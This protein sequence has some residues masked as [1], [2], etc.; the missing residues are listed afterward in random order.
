L[1]KVLKGMNK[2]NTYSIAI[3]AYGRPNELMELFDS[4]YQMDKQP[5]EIIICEDFSKDRKK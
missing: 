5:N 2:E 4:I 3:P 1:Q